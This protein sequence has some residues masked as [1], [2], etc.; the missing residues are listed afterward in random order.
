MDVDE[1]RLK[2]CPYGICVR[3]RNGSRV[4]VNRSDN[5]EPLTLCIVDEC[6]YWKFT[7]DSTTEGMCKS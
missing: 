3:G 7:G 6:M 5:D 4:N 1:A 2:W